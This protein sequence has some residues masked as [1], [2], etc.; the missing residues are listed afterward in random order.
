MKKILLTGASGAVGREVLLKL[1]ELQD[2]IEITVFDIET[3]ASK[4][5]YRKVKR[6]FKLIYG[7]ISRKEDISSACKNKDAIIH[8]A[9]IIPPVADKYPK[10]A[11]AVNIT[12]TRN[13]I[14]C[15]EDLSPDAFFIYSSSISVYGDRNNDPWIKNGDKLI[16]SERD[17]YARTKIEAEKIITGSKLDWT[18]FRLTAIMGT[19]NHK[20]SALMFHMPLDT[21]MEIATPGDTGRAFV[22]ALGHKEKLSRNIYNLGGGENCRISYRDFLSRSFKAMGLG[23][24]D[25][26]NNTFAG[27]NFHCG[28]YADGNVLNELLDFRRDTIEDYFKYLEKSV[29]P[30][31]KMAMAILR[32]VIKKNLERQSEPLAATKTNNIA[33][34][35][36]YF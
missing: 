28:Y 21:K 12:G 6:N 11:E 5:F 25:F 32:K 34:I 29:S 1:C 20:P 35:H 8:L 18:I 24:L 14:E 15:L 23:S 2:E 19:D 16:P 30:L 9:A 33:D 7:D 4:S 31:R 3:E 13:L 36:H 10:L 26:Q 17:E 22:N 27:K